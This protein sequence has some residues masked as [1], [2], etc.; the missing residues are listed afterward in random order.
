M[1][2]RTYA[3]HHN[4]LHVVKSGFSWPGFLVPTIWLLMRG[5]PIEG[6]IVVGMVIVTL[7]TAPTEWMG[8]LLLAVNLVAGF[9]TNRRIEAKYR[10]EGWRRLADVRATSVV[11][12]LEQAAQVP[13]AGGLTSA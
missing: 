5:L 6:A 7:A 2:F 10:A 8:L 4:R 11:D 9:F 13:A 3:D 1:T 12:A